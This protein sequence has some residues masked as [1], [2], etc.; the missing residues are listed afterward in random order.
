[1]NITVSLPTD[2]SIR[3]ERRFTAPVERVWEAYTNPDIV[4][5]WLAGPDPQTTF[6][7]CEMDIRPGGAFRWVWQNP[8]GRLEI[9]GDVLDVDA[10]HRLVTT[11]KMGDMPFPP[12]NNEIT[13]EEVDGETLMTGVITYASQEMRDGA[14][15]SGMAE[16]MDVSFDKLAELL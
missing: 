10:P 2:T 11:E 14:Y 15:A 4:R 7:V 3:Y 5:T 13:F 12:T 16:G 1:M 6:E 9:H 8:D